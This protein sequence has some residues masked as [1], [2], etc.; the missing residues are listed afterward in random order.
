M[1][2]PA[3]LE[4]FKRRVI[5]LSKNGRVHRRFASF[6]SSANLFGFV[7]K[8]KAKAT[9]RNGQRKQIVHAL[10]IASILFYDTKT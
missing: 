3:F 10:Y 9:I 7:F 4:Q 8:S 5:K 1:H 6:L 2:V